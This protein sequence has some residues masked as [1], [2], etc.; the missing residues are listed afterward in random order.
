MDLRTYLKKPGITQEGFADKVGEGVS[1]GL[2]GQWLTG[3]T[4][5][6]PDRAIEIEAATG[7]E[8]R[9]EDLRPDLDWQR[10]RKGLVTGYLVKVQRPKA[11][12]A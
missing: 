5:I 9:C 10:D 8:V 11:K 12:A 2:V 1:Q 4:K 7:G 6:T 3:R